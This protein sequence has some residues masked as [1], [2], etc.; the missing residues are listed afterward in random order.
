MIST[1]LFCRSGATEK[2]FAV[3]ELSVKVK[4]VE[5]GATIL[6]SKINVMLES[7]ATPV[8]RVDGTEDT[9]T[10][11]SVSGGTVVKDVDLRTESHGSQWFVGDTRVTCNTNNPDVTYTTYCKCLPFNGAYDLD[12]YAYYSD[13]RGN[14]WI[15][16]LEA[17]TTKVKC[18]EALDVHP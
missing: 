15:R 13:D 8:A 5:P 10:G 14:Q 3:R 11:G 7:T 2:V 6:S 12:L 1:V 9:N 18:L 4:S 16:T 17:F